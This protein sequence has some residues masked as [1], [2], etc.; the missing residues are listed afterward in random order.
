MAS[1]VVRAS[2]LNRVLDIL[3]KR[4]I[5]P[6]TL[7][8]LPGGPIRLHRLPP[9]ANDGSEEDEKAARAWDEALR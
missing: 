1:P 9:A 8:L 4:G 6:A 3:E 7:E 2:E 5:V